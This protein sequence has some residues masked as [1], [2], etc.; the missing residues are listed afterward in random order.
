MKISLKHIIA[1]SIVGIVVLFLLYCLFYFLF[2][3]LKAT[4]YLDCGKVISKSN[5]EIPIK[6]GTKTQ[7]YLNV[8][9]DKT[10]FKSV[11]CD[12]TTYFKYKV[13]E[14]VCFN[15]YDKKEN[16]WYILLFKGIG[17]IVFSCIILIVIALTWKTIEEFFY[18]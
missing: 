3:D 7:L 11:L 1:F 16:R 14:N 10:G 6:Y 18:S 5:D 9:F 13:G 17:L 12:P 8:Q 4:K 15:L 2:T